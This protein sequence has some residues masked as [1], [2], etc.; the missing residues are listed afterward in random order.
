MGRGGREDYVQGLSHRRWWEGPAAASGLGQRDLAAER[1]KDQ[2]QYLKADSG[3]S[4]YFGFQFCWDGGISVL[5]NVTD[6]LFID[7]HPAGFAPILN[8]LQTKELDL[9]G[10]SINVLKQE[11]EFYRI[12]PLVRKLLLHEELERSSCGSVLFHG[13]LPPPD[14]SSCKINNTTRICCWF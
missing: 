1:G 14:I 5:P 9:R 11:A 2:I 4:R 6:A 13:Y 8:F 3:R 12:T 10:V 7:R